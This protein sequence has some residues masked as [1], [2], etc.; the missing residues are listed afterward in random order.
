MHKILE[1]V[2]A[3]RAEQFKNSNYNLAAV[4]VQRFH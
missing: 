4:L 1:F 2:Y 3:V